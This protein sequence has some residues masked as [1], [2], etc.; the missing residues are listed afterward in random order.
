MCLSHLRILVKNYEVIHVESSIIFWRMISIIVVII[1][2]VVISGCT[3]VHT[4]DSP[5]LPTGGCCTET[6]CQSH[7]GPRLIYDGV[8]TLNPP[9]EETICSSR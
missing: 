9:R 2:R 7:D 6:A 4:R 5:Y 3:G 8:V 1:V